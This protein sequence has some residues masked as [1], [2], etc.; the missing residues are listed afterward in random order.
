MSM[1]HDWLSLLRTA[2]DRFATVLDDAEL[3]APVPSCPGWTLADLA[4]HVGGVHQWAA[5]AVVHG[6]PDGPFDGT[7]EPATGVAE[8]YRRHAAHLVDVLAERSPDTPAWTFGPEPHTALFWRRRQ[9]HEVEVHTWDALASQGR[10]HELESE[11]AWDGVAEVA[12]VFYPRQVRLARTAPLPRALRL[13]A[14]DRLDS[15]VLGG[16]DP[17]EVSATA[18]TLLLLL[19]HR[20][21]PASYDLAPEAVGLLGLALTP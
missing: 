14:T 17:V 6:T 13:V 16:G 20:A 7:F 9:V 12:T 19:W 3:A 1:E 2:T 11:L 4:E 10:R 21:D 5:H 8:W 15:V 18:E